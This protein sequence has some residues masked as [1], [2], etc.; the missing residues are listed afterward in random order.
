[1]TVGVEKLKI[2]LKSFQW[3]YKISE[4]FS[5]LQIMLKFRYI[6]FSGLQKLAQALGWS[7]CMLLRLRP[8]F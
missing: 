1:M 4:A 8:S 2:C 3:H 7:I 5:S 6:I